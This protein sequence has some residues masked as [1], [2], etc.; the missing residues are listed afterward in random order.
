M[1]FFKI[2]HSFFSSLGFN[3]LKIKNIFIVL[4]FIIKKFLW[5]LNLDLI[6]KKINFDE[7]YKIK[8]KN[9]PIIFDV[10]ANSG[11]SIKRFLTIFPKARIDS[12]EPIKSYCDIIQKKYIN[13]NIFINN[14]GLG[15][16]N[17]KKKFYISNYDPCSSFLKNNLHKLDKNFKYFK[18]KEI[19]NINLTTIDNYLRSNNINRIDILKIDT[20]GTEL[21]VL[22]GATFALKKKII[23]FIELEIIIKAHYKNQNNFYKID[24][25][26]SDNK[27]RLYNLHEFNYEKNF[28]IT[29]FDALYINTQINI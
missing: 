13:K 11:Q 9:N 6:K 28:M 19:I 5:N 25:I 27:F 3:L 21:E 26:L 29:Q 12:F 4:K 7:I 8:I 16:K 20:Q 23:K 1:R 17:S 14:L 18:T 10:G 2:L 22:K 24:K 15:Q